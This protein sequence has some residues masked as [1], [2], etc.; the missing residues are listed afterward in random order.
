MLNMQG[1]TH[2]DHVIGEDFADWKVPGQHRVPIP[3]PGEIV[4][5]ISFVRAGL[6]LSASAFLHRFPGTVV[7]ASVRARTRR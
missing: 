2:L 1:P 6:C 3:G 4:L 7:R 5:F